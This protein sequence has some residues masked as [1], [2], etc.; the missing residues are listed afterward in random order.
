MTIYSK[1]A[2]VILTIYLYCRYKIK[3]V[4]TPINIQIYKVI[5]SIAHT[6]DNQQ[7]ISYDSD[8]YAENFGEYSY[9]T[10]IY[11]TSKDIIGITENIEKTNRNKYVLW[12]PGG[13]DFFCHPFVTKELIKKGYDIYAV[14]LPNIGFAQYS[15]KRYLNYPTVGEII[16][17]LNAVV[18]L[19]DQ[20]YNNPE[21]VIY[22]ISLGS[23]IALYYIKLYPTLFSKCILN[24]PY[25][26]RNLNNIDNYII[27]AK[28]FLYLFYNFN[29]NFKSGELSKVCLS[30][31]MYD[32]RPYGISK[33]YINDIITYYSTNESIKNPQTIMRLENGHGRYLIKS[34]DYLI[35]KFFAYFFNYNNINT[36]YN[37]PTLILC[38]DISIHENN[39]CLDL[40]D[41]YFGLKK[42]GDLV[43]NVNCIKNNCKNMFSNHKIVQLKEA[44]HD[45]FYSEK[46]VRDKAISEFVNFL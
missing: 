37:I 14:D 21:R 8:N 34:N 20:K 25:I 18:G 32:I 30:M 10:N 41:N 35:T 27:D 22:G 12:I 11:N 16:G 24:G 44:S 5:E 39:V 15:N 4:T 46:E 9:I 1:I 17:Y 31:A 13:G 6:I 7:L 28:A 42:Y 45:V 40:N 3:H 26:D 43:V 2:L 29:F 23:I 19:I 36:V 38:S 33:G